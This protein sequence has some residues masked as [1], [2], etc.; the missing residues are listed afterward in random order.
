VKISTLC[1]RLKSIQRLT[2]LYKAMNA[3]SRRFPATSKPGNCLL[4]RG[5]ERRCCS[6][7]SAIL[8]NMEGAQASS[9][10]R[11]NSEN[12]FWSGT[13]TGGNVPRPSA[14]PRVPTHDQQRL[15]K[16]RHVGVCCRARP[17]QSLLQVREVDSGAAKREA[18]E[19]A[20]GPTPSQLV[21]KPGA[22]VGFTDQRAGI[23]N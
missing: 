22:F 16:W 12:A 19:I 8:S 7:R 10:S 15:S 6:G 14:T 9:V 20:Q 2:V 11:V 5:L 17:G 21:L 4:R 23:T 3:G 18:R 1:R 13:E